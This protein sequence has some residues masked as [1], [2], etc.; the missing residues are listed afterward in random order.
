MAMN[1]AEKQAMSDLYVRAAL[2]WPEPVMPIDLAVLF[3]GRGIGARTP[4]A[5]WT[6]NAH[7]DGWVSLGWTNGGLHSREGAVP[8][9]A[10]K[11]RSSASQTGG[12]P[13]YH[14]KIEALKALRY[15]MTA[16]AAKRL[17]AVDERIAEASRTAPD[18]L[19]EG[20]K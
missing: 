18:N 8:D 13:W 4:V 3:E 11:G 1:K 9:P 7:G 20:E 17:A 16:E 15:A 10:A 19:M 2:N 12:G 6:M 5:L 14:T